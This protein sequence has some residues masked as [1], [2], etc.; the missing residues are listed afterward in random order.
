MIEFLTI[1]QL[2]E[3]DGFGHLTHPHKCRGCGRWVDAKRL[4]EH[5]SECRSPAVLRAYRHRKSQMGKKSVH[6]RFHVARGVVK[7]TCKF[8][9]SEASEDVRRRLPE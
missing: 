2:A 7:D 4:D 1:Q 8:C 5:E 9:R 6:V 3:R